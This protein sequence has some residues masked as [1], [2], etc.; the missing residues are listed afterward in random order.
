MGAIH[1]KL[2]IEALIIMKVPRARASIFGEQQRGKTKHRPEIGRKP[3]N[4]ENRFIQKMAVSSK[5]C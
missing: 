2:I 5:L 4:Q 1:I 3:G